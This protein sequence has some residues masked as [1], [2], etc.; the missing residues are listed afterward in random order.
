MPRKPRNFQAGYSYHITTRCNNREF[1]LTRHECRQVF[2]YALKKALGKFQ[3]KL[4]GLCIMSNHVHYLLEPM[5]WLLPLGKQAA[6]KSS[7]A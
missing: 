5:H 6:T 7:Q 1:Q 4:Y 3:F 2:L